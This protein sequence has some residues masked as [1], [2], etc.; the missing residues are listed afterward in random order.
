MKTEFDK[1]KDMYFKYGGKKFHMLRNDVLEEY[2]AYKISESTENE[3]FIELYKN[4]VKNMDIDDFISIIVVIE[5]LN[6]TKT[7]YED[8]FKFINKNSKK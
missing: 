4:Y 1:A 2:E 6:D 8:V 5:S 3:W 7:K